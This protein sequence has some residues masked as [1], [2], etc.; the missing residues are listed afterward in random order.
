[1]YTASNLS[2]RDNVWNHMAVTVDVANSNVKF[3][4][5]NSNVF[6]QSN[7]AFN[8]N[9]NVN[10]NLYVAHAEAE[11]NAFKGL[12]DN[13]QLYDTAVSS[14]QMNDLATFPVLNLDMTPTDANLV[15][16]MSSFQN[17]VT[18][19]N[20]P[21]STIYGYQPTNKALDFDAS[22]NQALVV[23]ASNVQNVNAKQ[24]TLSMWVKPT[25]SSGG[26][27]SKSFK[28]TS[29]NTSYLLNST[30]MSTVGTP[31][32]INETTLVF[33]SKNYDNGRHVYLYN[34]TN[35][36]KNI[37]WLAGQGVFQFRTQND[38]SLINISQSV[39]ADDEW[40]M[41]V[42]TIYM[43]GSTMYAKGYIDNS[44]NVYG[45]VTV[46]NRSAFIQT[47]G[48]NITNIRLGGNRY[49]LTNESHLDEVSLFRGQLSANDVDKLYNDK[50][51]PKS[52]ASDNSA[53]LYAYWNFEDNYDDNGPN[54]NQFPL[55]LNGSSSEVEFS[56]D[57][58]FTEYTGSAS[59]SNTPLI[60]KSDLFKLSL[61]SD[62][63]PVLSML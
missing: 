5:N 53:T 33:W 7:V 25:S 20:S 61:D 10:S 44:T 55:S 60:A 42:L 16:D 21:S 39:A 46:P 62:N 49:S 11:S 40:H 36:N 2:I 28:K 58:P 23:S 6:T 48:W 47:A 17:T 18:M 59:S 52:L 12:I 24:M 38:A 26:T 30:D 41:W 29:S 9:S 31:L 1:M 50:I 51:S 8:I 37:H 15:I 13:V 14:Y 35:T 34:T 57:T 54:G 3:Y 19:S 43:D 45:P 32:N 56:T 63:K 27:N 4:L 22:I